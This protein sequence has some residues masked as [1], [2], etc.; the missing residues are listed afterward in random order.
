M[1]GKLVLNTIVFKEK[2]DRGI[3]QEELLQDVKDLGINYMEVR[4]EFVKDS[5]QELSAI[6]AK[7][8]TLGIS[9]LYSIN[10]DFVVNGKPNEHLATYIAEAQCLDACVLKMNTG[11]ATGLAVDDLKALTPLFETSL[12]ISVENNQ[13]PHHA[14][15]ANIKTFLA[16]TDQAG[17]PIRF[18]FDTGNWHWVG[19]T[20]QEAL[21]VFK[22]ATHYLHMKNFQTTEAGLSTTGLFEGELDIVSVAKSFDHLDYYAFE[23]PCSEETLK[24]D[25]ETFKNSLF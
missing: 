22:T 14:T 24:Q 18:V 25:I 12:Q 4:R 23:Y 5:L 9:L 7:A 19:E 17:L 15:I 3:L 16:L 11:D 21:T 10:E 2:L 6:A 1:Q 20:T 8:K 13:T